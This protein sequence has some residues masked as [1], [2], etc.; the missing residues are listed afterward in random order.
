MCKFGLAF[1]QLIN[2]VSTNIK[3]ITKNFDKTYEKVEGKKWRIKKILENN[4]E[5]FLN[6]ET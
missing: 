1:V 5:T 6:C 3:N 2:V 4:L